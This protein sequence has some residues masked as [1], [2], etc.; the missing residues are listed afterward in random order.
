MTPGGRI[1]IAEH[2]GAQ[3]YE[4]SSLRDGNVVR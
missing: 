1:G 3:F 2:E 4:V